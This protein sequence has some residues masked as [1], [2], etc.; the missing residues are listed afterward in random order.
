MRK[1]ERVKPQ[2]LEMDAVGSVSSGSSFG[3][4]GGGKITY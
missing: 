1:S 2:R 4:Q 3:K